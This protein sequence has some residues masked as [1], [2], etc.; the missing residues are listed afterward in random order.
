MGKVQV[1]YW[2]YSDGSACGVV[3]VYKNEE[4]A[5]KDLLML[6][7]HCQGMKD[8]ELVEVEYSDA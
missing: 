8:F 7:E 5:E 2:K 3:R 1:I 4:T 6:R